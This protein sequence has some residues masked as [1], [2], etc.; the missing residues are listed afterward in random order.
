MDHIACHS[1]KHS[2]FVLFDSNAAYLK[3]VNLF[4]GYF[5]GNVSLD[6]LKGFVHCLVGILAGQR[7]PR[8]A[9]TQPVY[10]CTYTL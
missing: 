7:N 8:A 3:G 6:V 1:S 2:A 10:R 4:Q 5:I 9:Q